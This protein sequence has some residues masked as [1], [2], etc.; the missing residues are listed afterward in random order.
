TWKHDDPAFSATFHGVRYQVKD[1]KR[2]VEFYTRQFG[3]SLAHQQPPAFANISLGPLH[4]LLSGPGASGSR[5]LADG[6]TQAPGGWNRI[7]L[8]VV[9]LPSGSARPG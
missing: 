6:R 3:F 7:V 4:V 2:A 8:R 5:P 1:M 9:N